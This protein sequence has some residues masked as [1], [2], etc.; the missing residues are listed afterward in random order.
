MHAL[1][2]SSPSHPHPACLARWPRSVDE[3]VYHTAEALQAAPALTEHFQLGQATIERRSGP[4]TLALTLAL[5]IA[6]SRATTSDA[7]SWIGAPNPPARPPPTLRT[8][9]AAATRTACA[10]AALPPLGRQPPYPPCTVD[11]HSIHDLD[12][13]VQGELQPPTELLQTECY[14]RVFSDR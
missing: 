8:T 11:A 9:A 2:D 4:K 14:T 13:E 3:N 5:A 6:T 1:S 12:I 7:P 10:R